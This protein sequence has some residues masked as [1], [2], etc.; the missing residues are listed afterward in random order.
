MG[1]H[2]ETHV[3]DV[4]QIIDKI[5]SDPKIAASRNF[6]ARVYHDEPILFAAPRMEKY[7]PREIRE[8]RLL[9]RAGGSDARVFYEQGKFMESFEDSFDYRGEF[10][11]YFPTYQAM[12]DAQLRGYF[13][14]RA[15]VRRGDV[16]ATSLS[17]AFVYIYELL[18]QIGVDSPEGGYHALKGF[19]TAYKDFDS[20]ITNYAALW[21]KDYVVY[22]DLDKSLLAGLPDDGVDDAVAV[23]LDYASHG[24]EEVF[25]ALNSLSAY[26]LEGSR[27]YRQYPDD[28]RE[29]VHTIFSVVSAY[30]NRNPEKG[31]REKLFGRIC[32]ADYAM[33]RSAVFH[34]R[35][36]QSDRV[37]EIANGHRYLC[38]GG[39][40]LCE[41]FIW[42]GKK[43]K[44]IGDLLKTVDYLM[45]QSRGFKSA[46]QP[47]KTNKILR[48]KMEKEIAAFE[49]R[50]RD[51]APRPIDIDVS[52]LH[53]IRVAALATQNKL[54]VEEAIAAEPP[55]RPVE[56]PRPEPELEPG[57]APAT[58][59][60]LE[61]AERGFL[62]RLIEGREY[63]DL[64]QSKGVMLS[65]LVDGINE[66]LFDAFGDTVIAMDE[67][68]PALIEDYR[69]EVKGM[70]A[71]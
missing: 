47:G 41:R 54:L 51:S 2:K 56:P 5:M 28:V 33:F 18:N 42:Y 11:Q 63:G 22:H 26:D 61:D 66:K 14:W 21:L 69:E 64:L 29:I 65:M 1:S 40:W 4:Q 17:F 62:L 27:F 6:S 44:R 39:R 45:R 50:K 36:G 12:T 60:G 38:R 8:M 70:L 71:Q 31:A 30:Y 20:R 59:A 23:L 43:N 58:G 24:A 16:A 53:G 13:S 10:S 46:F 68:G 7:T 55:V 9:A 57:P 37:Y 32:T 19:W 25:S 34:Y 52:K 15:R 35:V 3:A 49:K 67:E 48:A